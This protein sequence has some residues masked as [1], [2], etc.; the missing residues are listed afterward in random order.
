MKGTA[1]ARAVV[2][3]LRGEYPDAECALHHRNVYELAVATILSAQCT[4]EMVNKVTPE[5]FWRYPTPEKLARARTATVERVVHRT[6]FFRNKAKNIQGMA[7]RLVEEFGGEMP[8]TLDELLT[9][10]GVAR[11]TG[12][13]ILGVGFGL[14]EG[15]VVDTHVKR[16]TKRLGLTE[17]TDPVKVERDLMEVVARA[18]WIDVSLLLIWHGRRVCTARKPACDCCLLADH[19]PSAGVPA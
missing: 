6:G 14:A 9:L 2:A 3:R 1:W 17:Q 15:V 11:K 10:P 4:D 8:R 12:G 5:L 16:I 18:D 7:R 19:C 13:V